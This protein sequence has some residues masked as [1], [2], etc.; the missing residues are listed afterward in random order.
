MGVDVFCIVFEYC[1]KT[2]S[3]RMS[4]M[5][6]WR[7]CVGAEERDKARMWDVCGGIWYGTKERGVPEKK[8]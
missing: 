5:D 6:P 3:D 7:V 2:T 1:N 4:K 8:I